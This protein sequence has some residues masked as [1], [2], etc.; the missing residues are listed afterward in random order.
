MIKYDYRIEFLSFLFPEDKQILNIFIQ[1]ILAEIG[2]EFLR[3]ASIHTPSAL[4]TAMGL[5]AGVILGDIA[6]SVGLFSYQTV[7]IVS[8]SAIGTYAT[9]SYEL[10]LANKLS[11]LFL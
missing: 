7:L 4:S 1:V 5:I 10:G 3:M 11:K 6:V 9:P 2:V 8:L